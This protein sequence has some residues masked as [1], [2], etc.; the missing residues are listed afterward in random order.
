MHQCES[1]LLG[2]V[3]GLTAQLAEDTVNDWA[4][5]SVTFLVAG[6]DLCRLRVAKHVGDHRHR[7]TAHRDPCS[8][9]GLNILV[10][11]AAPAPTRHH[12]CLAR[13]TVIVDH[14]ENRLMSAAAGPPD[15]I[16]QQEPMAQQPTQTPSVEPT[17]TLKY[18]AKKRTRA[19][20]HAAMIALDRQPTPRA[21][22]LRRSASRV[23]EGLPLSIH[24]RG[25]A[26]GAA[27]GALSALI[28]PGRTRYGPGASLRPGRPAGESGCG[29]GTASIPSTLPA[30]SV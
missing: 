14:F 18:H 16:Q 29:Y 2:P 3:V 12:D 4:H 15:V 19:M 13:G 27:S 8:S 22:Y 26:G 5:P 25:A 21:H 1:A 20:R 24:E 7:L 23:P 10:P 17:R 9:G 11:V 30:L 28:V 6:K